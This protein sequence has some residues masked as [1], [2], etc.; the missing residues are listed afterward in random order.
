[1]EL[2]ETVGEGGA[3]YQVAL[4][5]PLD[6]GEEEGTREVRRDGEGLSIILRDAVSFTIV[7]RLQDAKKKKAK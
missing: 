3:Y 6:P 7:L 2:G 1:M 5:P 4:G